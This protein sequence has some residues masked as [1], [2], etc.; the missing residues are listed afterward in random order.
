LES[1]GA[2]R[3]AAGL[4]RNWLKESSALIRVDPIHLKKS[5]L[6]P[7]LP[8]PPNQRRHA[9]PQ[10]NLCPICR[11]SVTARAN[12]LQL[13]TTKQLNPIRH[14]RS[15]PPSLSLDATL[16]AERTPP[17]HGHFQPS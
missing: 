11:F 14:P 8:K 2:R 6:N 9:F 4:L 15:A 12:I 3:P 13:H 1:R 10:N 16:L 7:T 5:A 17:T